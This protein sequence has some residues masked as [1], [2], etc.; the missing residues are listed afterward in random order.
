MGTLAGEKIMTI[1]QSITK[2][3]LNDFLR[4]PETKPASEYIEGKIQQKSMPKGKHSAI[5]SSVVSIINQL[6]ISY[7]KCRAFSEL[8]CTFGGRSLIPDIS[9]F[10]WLRIPLDE[11]GEI[12]NDFVIFP[13][14]TIEILSPEQSSIRVIDKILFCLNQGTELGWLID[15]KERIIMTFLGNQQPQIHQGEEQL[16]V[17]SI[18]S[19][20]RISASDIFACLTLEN[21]E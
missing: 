10:S 9:V 21:R 6:S 14:W 12:E 4:L 11:N 13:D 17:L 5:Q 20:W 16:P 19:N 15:P 1:I 3:T 7:R 18:L 2:L 8:R